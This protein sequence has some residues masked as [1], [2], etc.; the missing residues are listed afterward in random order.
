MV[1]HVQMREIDGRDYEGNNGIAAVVLRVG[2]DGNLSLSKSS[3]YVVL[4]L[5]K[6]IVIEAYQYLL[7]SHYPNQRRR[8]RNHL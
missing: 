1:Y 2:E 7:H 8:Y 3:L 6:S 5:H 4:V